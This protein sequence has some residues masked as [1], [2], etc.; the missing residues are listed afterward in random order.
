MIIKFPVKKEEIVEKEVSLPFFYKT[1]EE[2]P[3]FVKIVNE[4]Q[5][6]VTKTD[7]CIIGNGVT[8][9]ETAMN[10]W[11]LDEQITAE[12]Y[13]QAYWMVNLEVKKL[14]CPE[15]ILSEDEKAD[16]QNSY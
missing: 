7:P 11:K 6:V 14:A 13:E 16:F 15:Y 1:A 3:T 2:Y 4:K 5:A 10:Y 12:E 9:P 8:S